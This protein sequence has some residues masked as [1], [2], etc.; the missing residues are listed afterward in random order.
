LTYGGSCSYELKAGCGYPSIRLD[1]DNLDIL[2]AYNKT[3]WKS[4]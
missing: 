4:D 2:L 1:G 3:L